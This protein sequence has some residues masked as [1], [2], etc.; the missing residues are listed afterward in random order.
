MNELN[1]IKDQLDF[2]VR[3]ITNGFITILKHEIG[4]THQSQMES[5]KNETIISAQLY[6]KDGLYKV[7]YIK[8]NS[9][10]QLVEVLNESEG[11]LPN[12]FMN[13]NKENWCLLTDTSTDKDLEI[14]LPIKNR[15]EYSKP[16]GKRQFPGKFLGSFNNIAIFHDFDIYFSKSPDKLLKI[17]FKKEKV[18]SQKQIKI[19]TPINNKISIDSDGNLQLLARQK[20]KFIHRKCDLNGEILFQREIPFIMFNSYEILT[21]NENGI[22]KVIFTESNKIC[23]SAIKVDSETTNSVIYENTSDIFNLWP[24]IQFGEDIWL[25]RFNFET[26]NGWLIIKED[27]LLDCFIHDNFNGYKST[28]TKEII[29]IQNNDLIL[30]DITKVGSDLYC[31]TIY[32]RNE[33]LKDNKELIILNKRI[34]AGNTR[35]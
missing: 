21:L 11:V 14:V 13:E 33:N 27:N 6:D 24:P 10:G 15:I 4:I 5:S 29:H 2:S 17:E 20:D 28:I 3:E 32:P 23:L 8:I 34:T 18:K 7:V 19:P 30:S 22:T 1:D 12:L 25:I 9:L 26:G 35:L 31:L 16:K